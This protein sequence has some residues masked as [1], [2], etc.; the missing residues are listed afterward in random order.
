VRDN[1]ALPSLKQLS[2][3]RLVS[4]RRERE[5]AQS[6]C[7]R[8]NVRTPGTDQI[9]GFLSGGNQ[10]KVVLAKWLAHPPRV[11]IL[12]EPTRGIDVGAKTEIYSLMDRLASQGVAILMISSDLE[13]VLGMS[14]RVLVMHEGHLNG[15]LGRSAMTEE[16][17]MHLATGGEP[18][19]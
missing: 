9:V 10:Q 12:D 14:D 6:M 5:L 18:R 19:S 11:L 8:L 17:I 3:L 4:S 1:I 15:E 13:E 2:W 16:T 7:E